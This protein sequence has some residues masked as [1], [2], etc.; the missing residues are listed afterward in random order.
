MHACTHHGLGT[1][2]LQGA[3][4]LITLNQVIRQPI[5]GKAKWNVLG[6]TGSHAV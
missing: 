1:G 2:S 6:L 5:S 3:Y 4:F